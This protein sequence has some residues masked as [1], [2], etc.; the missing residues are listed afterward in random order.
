[1]VFFLAMLIIRALNGA[2][3][4]VRSERSKEWSSNDTYLKLT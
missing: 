4:V 2:A 1:M 3:S